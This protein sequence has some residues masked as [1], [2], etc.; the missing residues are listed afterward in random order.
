MPAGHEEQCAGG[1]DGTA[2][3]GAVT[4]LAVGND[5][6]AVPHGKELLAAGMDA[7]PAAVAALAVNKDPH[8]VHLHASFVPDHS[9]WML[10]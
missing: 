6:F 3:P 4:E 8:V 5:G 10:Q 9:P 7:F 1:T 2:F